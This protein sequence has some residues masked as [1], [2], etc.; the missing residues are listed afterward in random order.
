MKRKVIRIVALTVVILG[1]VLL[2]R[3]VW[4][5]SYRADFNEKVERARALGFP[6]NPDEIR[7]MCPRSGKTHSVELKFEDGFQMN[8]PHLA[9]HLQ[10]CQ[11]LAAG[12]RRD[13]SGSD[14]NSAAE[15]CVSMYD[16]RDALL[17]EPVMLSFR[18]AQI[19]DQNAQKVVREILKADNLTADICRKLIPCL[20]TAPFLKSYSNVLRG[21]LAIGI[22]EIGRTGSARFQTAAFN[23]TDSDSINWFL[24][25]TFWKSS[26]SYVENMTL[27][28]RLAECDYYCA[29]KR[30]KIVEVESQMGGELDVYIANNIMPSISRSA[31]M[32]AVMRVKDDI[33]RLGVLARIEL[34][35]TG[36]LPDRIAR[37][38]STRDPF[39]GKPY[40]I[41][42]V[43]D[44]M[45]I[46][47]FGTNMKE[48]GGDESLDIVF[49]IEYP[50]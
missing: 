6:T 27:L 48:D 44:S 45:A 7:A 2:S 4:T 11:D 32:F 1:S 40:N 13:I 49:K 18:Y 3:A 15:K 41:K 14:L 16:F 12:A 28:I 39:S 30:L 8:L 36:K 24:K 19:I 23:T 37:I 5:W 31:E 38:E 47:S 9:Q 50:R 20:E 21:E 43:S 42:S 29:R 34:L 25:P 10:R 26:A 33:L 35:S 22:Y 46:Y 17:Q